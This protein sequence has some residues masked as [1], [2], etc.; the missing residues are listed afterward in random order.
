MHLQG[1]QLVPELL[2]ILCINI[3]YV[4]ILSMCMKKCHV[5][6]CFWLNNCFL[7]LAIFYGLCSLDISFLY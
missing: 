7:N 2:L 1:N 5:K 4:D 3:I 6:K